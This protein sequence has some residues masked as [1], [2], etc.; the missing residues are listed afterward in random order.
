MDILPWSREV[1]NNAK[2]NPPPPP[3]PTITIFDVMN[4]YYTCKKQRLET[5]IFPV[6]LCPKSA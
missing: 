6:Q 5:E 3:P 1:L 4:V 2:G